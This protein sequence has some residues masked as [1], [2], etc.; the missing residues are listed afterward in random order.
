[1]FTRVLHSA[2]F[3]ARKFSPTKDYSVNKSA[4]AD[5]EDFY[6][7]CNPHGFLRQTTFIVAVKECR[8][9]RRDRRR[10]IDLPTM[11]QKQNDAINSRIFVVEIFEKRF[12]HCYRSLERDRELPAFYT[13]PLKRVQKK[14]SLSP[15]RNRVYLSRNSYRAEVQLIIL[16]LLL[17][18]CNIF[19]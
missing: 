4:I 9:F 19:K 7:L 2:M 16:F 11:W 14:L 10:C 1:M 5:L 8:L 12:L 13:S 18:S 6:A 15:A 17:L 3:A